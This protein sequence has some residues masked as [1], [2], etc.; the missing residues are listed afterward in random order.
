MPKVTRGSNKRPKKPPE[1]GK[2]TNA[3]RPMEDQ[4]DCPHPINRRI[5]KMC[6][7]CGKDP[8]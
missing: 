5:G 3:G 8:V 2:H 4:K 1:Q 6:A 7:R